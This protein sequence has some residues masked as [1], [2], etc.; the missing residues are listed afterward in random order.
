[1]KYLSVALKKK[2]NE[3]NQSIHGDSFTGLLP[4]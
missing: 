3:N 4:S 2:D 1:M